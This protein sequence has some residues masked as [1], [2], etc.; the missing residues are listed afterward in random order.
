MYDNWYG[1]QRRVPWLHITMA[2]TR[3]PIRVAATHH[4]CHIG[5][6]GRIRHNPSEGPAHPRPLAQTGFGTCFSGLAATRK[7]DMIE[8]GKPCNRTTHKAQ[9]TKP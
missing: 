2:K 1:V 5:H 8:D 4:A 9:D 7:W 3:D 6:M